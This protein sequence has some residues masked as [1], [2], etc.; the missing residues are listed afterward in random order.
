MNVI[1][2]TP[3]KNTFTIDPIRGAFIKCDL[4]GSISHNQGDI[5]NKYCGRCHLHHDAVKAARAQYATGGFTHTCNEWR[6]ALDICAICSLFLS[7]RP[8]A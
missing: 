4:C 6:T 5:E 3:E 7:P 8:A 1:N 2:Q